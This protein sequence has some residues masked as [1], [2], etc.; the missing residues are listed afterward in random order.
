MS[1]TVGVKGSDI[2]SHDEVDSRIVLSTLLVRGCEPITIK[3]K[4]N[5][6]LKDGHLVDAIVLAFMTRNTRGGKGERDLFVTMYLTLYKCYKDLASFLLELIPH[7][8]SWRDVFDLF[9]KEPN[10]RNS[11]IN[12]VKKQ[13][14]EDEKNM[15]LGKSV[16]LLAKWIPRE[17]NQYGKEFAYA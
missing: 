17:R 11:I 1:T 6:V 13:L 9:T 3:N 10:L 14:E 12:L 5:E 16:S 4:F 7:Y 8:G 15:A 2:Y